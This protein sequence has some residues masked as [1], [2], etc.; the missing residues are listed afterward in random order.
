MVGATVP[1][2]VLIAWALSRMANELD[3]VS[4]D[5]WSTLAV[6]VAFLIGWGLARFQRARREWALWLGL[7]LIVIG[8]ADV[9]DA[10]PFAFDFAVV[11]PI[12]IIGLG[13]YLIYRNR[14]SLGIGQRRPR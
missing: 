8:L 2:L 14:A 11:I 5:G 3:V 12:A 4:G 10:L 1:A 6:G 9:S 7:I 13:V